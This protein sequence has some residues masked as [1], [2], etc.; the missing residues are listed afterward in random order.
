MSLRVDSS[1]G[2][3]VTLK[4]QYIKQSQRGGPH[5]IYVQA[6]DMSSDTATNWICFMAGK[7]DNSD[8]F[9]STYC[10]IARAERNAGDEINI[11]T[12]DKGCVSSTYYDLTFRYSTNDA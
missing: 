10:Q 3:Y 2:T 1:G 11:L 6:W 4:P 8:N 5:A 12:D 7:S 9:C